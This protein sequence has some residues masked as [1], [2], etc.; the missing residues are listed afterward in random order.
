MLV[1]WFDVPPH[2]VSDFKTFCA[3]YLDSVDTLLHEHPSVWL[4]SQ[5]TLEFWQNCTHVDRTI[6]ILPHLSHTTRW[7]HDALPDSDSFYSLTP[8]THSLVQG[9]TALWLVQPHDAPC[10]LSEKVDRMRASGIT[11]FILGVPNTC[12][13]WKHALEELEHTGTAWRAIHGHKPTAMDVHARSYPG[14][15]TRFG[16]CR[17][18]RIPTPSQ[19]IGGLMEPPTSI[20]LN[21]WPAPAGSPNVERVTGLCPPKVT[22]TH[23]ANRQEKH[24]TGTDGTS[25]RRNVA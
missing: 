19:L 15:H 7:Q 5:N 10:R 3:R 11:Q 25:S 1:T 20:Y 8:A 21:L 9:S 6:G 14:T 13:D 17:K 4:C 22:R 12:N 2:S 23:L 16:I 18:K 24:C